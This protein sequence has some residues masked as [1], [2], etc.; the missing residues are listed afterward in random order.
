MKLQN[1][2]LAQFEQAVTLANALTYGHLKV[3][4]DAHEFGTRKVGVQGRLT[5]D[6]SYAKGARLSSSGRHIQAA[7]WHA[8]RDVIR[9]LFVISPD[10]IVTTSL[11]KYTA[12]N[13]E[14]TYPQTGNVNIGSLFYPVTMPELCDC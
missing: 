9:E 3:H 8:F 7:C 13:F 1:V 14:T 6:S 10:A 11:A 2:T 12:A 5:V 4:P